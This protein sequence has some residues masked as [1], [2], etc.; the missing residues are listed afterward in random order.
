MGDVFFY[1]L[2]QSTLDTT[3]PM[4]VD[5][6]MSREWR[7]AIRGTDPARLDHL[8]NRLWERDGFLPH[9]IA[10]GPHDVLQPVLLTSDKAAPNGAQFLLA[11]DGATIDPDEMSG[12]ERA[13]LLFEGADAAAV[14]AARNQWR[15][16]TAAGVA[17]VYWAEEDGRWV[18]KAESAT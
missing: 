1:H 3:L 12:L 14:E 11:V 10:G 18:K 4:L 9:G 2:T 17:A 6:A 8:D 15:T 16:L 7:V 13:C 5:R